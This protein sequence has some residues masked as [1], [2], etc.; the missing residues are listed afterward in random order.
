VFLTQALF[1][2]SALTPALAQ[3]EKPALTQSDVPADGIA[4]LLDYKE[5]TS[6]IADADVRL[7]P[8]AEDLLKAG[9]RAG[10]RRRESSR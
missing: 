6:P 3:T 2:C 4:R 9:A 10:N 1:F 5:L 7:G 8:E